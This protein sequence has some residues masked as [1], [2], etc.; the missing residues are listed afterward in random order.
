VIHCSGEGPGAA[1][2]P[3]TRFRAGLS[4]GAA[5]ADLLFNG[6]SHAAMVRTAVSGSFDYQ[7]T[8]TTTLSFGA[9]VGTGGSLTVSRIHYAIRP[10]WLA[11]GSYARRLVDGEG[12]LPFVILGLSFG[13]SGASTSASIGGRDETAPLYAFDFRGGLTVGKT[14]LDVLSPYVAARLFGGPVLW[15]LQGATALGTDENHYQLAAGLVIAL[16]RRFDAFVEGA[17]LGE[18]AV[19]VGAGYSF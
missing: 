10:G 14:F 1:A 8:G 9:G 18:R 6:T 16:P 5:G 3:P 7:L 11:T 13:A 12:S 17:P 4:Y 2:G 19:T 15:K